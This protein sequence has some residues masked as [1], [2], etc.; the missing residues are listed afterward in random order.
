MSAPI[1]PPLRAGFHP[2]TGPENAPS[3]NPT[4][5]VVVIGMDTHD[6]TIDYIA[7]DSNGRTRRIHESVLRFAV[8]VGTS[9]APTVDVIIGT[10]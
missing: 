4:E 1:S 7:I 9:F 6:G 5:R 2:R 3:L 8:S 10:I